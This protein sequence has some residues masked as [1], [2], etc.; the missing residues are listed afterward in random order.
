MLEILDLEPVA[1]GALVRTLARV[2]AKMLFQVT[3]FPKR[4]VTNPTL[5][6]SGHT[7]ALIQL[8]LFRLHLRHANFITGIAD[9]KWLLQ[10]HL[11]YQTLRFR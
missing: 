7:D 6:W 3:D 1:L 10:Y 2:S 5:V 9:N 8:F 4:C 11:R